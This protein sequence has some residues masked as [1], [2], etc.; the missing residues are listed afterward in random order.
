MRELLDDAAVCSP[1]AFRD[2]ATAACARRVPLWRYTY[3]AEQIAESRRCGIYRQ[4]YAALANVIGEADVYET[5]GES[6]LEE[7]R[8]IGW[9]RRLG[10]Q[11]RKLLQRA[12]WRSR[13]GVTLFTQVFID[14]LWRLCPSPGRL[15]KWVHRVMHRASKIC[16]AWHCHASY[17]QLAV[18]LDAVFLDAKASQRLRLP[19]VGTAALCVAALTVH[20]RFVGTGV[21]REHINKRWARQTLIDARY[22]GRSRPGDA[23]ARKPRLVPYATESLFVWSDYDA[24][25]VGFGNTVGARSRIFACVTCP[26]TGTQYRLPVPPQFALP[27]A[28]GETVA[29]RIRA[30]VN[31]TFSLPPNAV[32]GIET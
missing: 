4:L 3:S 19:K 10:R 1:T 26:T 15:E 23:P 5:W 11:S 21:P 32:L 29:A 28:D 17:R 6:S 20:S 14:D 12:T 27:L 24:A 16:A 2:A 8:L 7:L 30:A 9:L 22:I 31:W 13:T 25:I 18:F